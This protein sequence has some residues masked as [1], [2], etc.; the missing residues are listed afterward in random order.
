MWKSSLPILGCVLFAACGSPPQYDVV[1]LNGNV[2]DG[3]GSE[4]F[5]GGV[6]ISSDTIALVWRSDGGRQGPRGLKEIDAAGRAVA[7]GFINVLSWAAESLIE[8]GRGQSDIRQGVTLDVF[9]EGWSMGPLNDEM[10]LVVAEGNQPGAQQDI[11]FDVEWTTLG[12]FLDYLV[13]SG[14][15]PNV[16]SFVGATTVRI[17]ELG[18]ENRPP[19]PDELAR[20]Q[21]LV[22]QAMKEGALGLGSSLIYAPAFYAGTGELVAL[23]RAAGEHGGVY[24]SHLRS[25]GNRLLEALDE[26]ITISR[27]AGVPAQIYHL[28]A[29]GK[30]NWGKLDAVIE[31]VEAA[32]S[33]GL[34]IT[35]DM[36]TY[37]AAATGFDA[38]MPP[39]VQEGGHEA[40]V[41]RL[42]DPA[43]RRRVIREMRTPT[44]EWENFYLAAGSSENVLV[45]GFRNEALKPLTGRTLSD[46]AAERG[47]SAEEAAIDLVIQD[48]SEVKVVYFV[49]SEENVRKKIALPWMSF[50]SDAAAVAP[51]GVFLRSNPHPRAYGS[52]ARLLGRYVREEGVIPL[53]EAVRRLTSFP[54]TTLGL[55]RRGALEPGYY[56]DIVIFDPDEIRD[57]ATF[58]EPHQYATGVAHVFVNGVHTL[59]D[60]EHTGALAGRVVRGP[61]WSGAH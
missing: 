14:V 33:E 39:W 8:D 35:A 9:G 23:A 44:D 3:S 17:H 6:A 18:H 21:D 48:D 59:A 49:M 32:R 51:E 36:Y 38:A 54:A 34:R 27:E 47:T 46:V 26:L 12:D 61:G 20:M 55:K 5:L 50:D 56:A 25:E 11:E 13:E 43:V 29:L 30:E 10:K 4:P 24:I 37:T 52:F 60:G 45:V 2:Y 57:H 31:R 28:K 42:R 40:W 1:I 53:E 41:E 7:P 19:T 58:A 22:R 15:S 16:A